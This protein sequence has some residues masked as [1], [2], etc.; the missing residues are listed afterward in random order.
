MN[1]S[2]HHGNQGF[3]DRRSRCS[4][5]PIPV[6]FVVAARVLKLIKQVRVHTVD[7]DDDRYVDVCMYIWMISSTIQTINNRLQYSLVLVPYW[8]V[9]KKNPPKSNIL[10]LRC[11][12][13]PTQ[14]VRVRTYSTVTLHTVF[15]TCI[16]NPK[17]TEE[18]SYY[19]HQVYR[20]MR[21][22]SGTVSTSCHPQQAAIKSPQQPESFSS[23]LI[24]CEIHSLT[25]TTT[26]T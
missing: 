16:P 4:G 9:E 3:H 24:L 25:T 26:T 10:D 15:C 5:I 18:H 22:A 11:R 21:T 23:R 12:S 6:S 2:S 1:R 17:K 20:Q 7:D 19:A 14:N 8:L 13:N